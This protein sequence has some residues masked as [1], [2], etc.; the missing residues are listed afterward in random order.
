MYV[1]QVKNSSHQITLL[2]GTVKIAAG[3]LLIFAPQLFKF[4]NYHFR[5]YFLIT[6]QDFFLLW[7]F[8]RK[9]IV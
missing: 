1:Y 4:L 6:V 8:F 3:Q 9:Y 5:F 7:H 2:K